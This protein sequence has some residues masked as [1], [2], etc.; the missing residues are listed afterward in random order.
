MDSAASYV[1]KQAVV[2]GLVN[3]LGHLFAGWVT[4]RQ[5]SANRAAQIPGSTDAAR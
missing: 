2:T 1:R 4:V 5:L 3:A